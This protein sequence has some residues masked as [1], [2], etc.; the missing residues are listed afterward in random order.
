[1]SYIVENGSEGKKWYL[2]SWE[3]DP[4]RTLVL[5]HA[6]KYRTIA[7]AKCAISIAQRRYPYRKSLNNCKIKYIGDLS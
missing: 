7:G 3:G 2:A 5:N 6:K 4:G 1:M